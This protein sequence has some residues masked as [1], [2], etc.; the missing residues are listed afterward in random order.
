VEEVVDMAS[1]DVTRGGRDGTVSCEGRGVSFES[2]SR[3]S[4]G[5][6]GEEE[7]VKRRCKSMTENRLDDFLDVDDRLGEMGL[8]VKGELMSADAGVVGTPRSSTEGEVSV[9]RR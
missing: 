9:S 1:F 4:T 3:S 5:M 6:E 7:N 8:S 2:W